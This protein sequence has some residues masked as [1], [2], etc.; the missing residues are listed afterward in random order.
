M[1]IR[2]ARL[3]ALALSASGHERMV[4]GP[5]AASKDSGLI[6]PQES[7]GLAHNEIEGPLVEI[8]SRSVFDKSAVGLPA[9]ASGGGAAYDLTPLLGRGVGREDCDESSVK[10]KGEAGGDRKAPKQSQFDRVLVIGRSQFRTN[11]GG[12][13]QAKRTQFP[14]GGNET[15][16]SV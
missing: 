7:P 9:V 13:G 4:K 6:S 2:Q 10:P 14:A 15:Q 3:E 1:A 16:A 12:I 11:R 5:M 8:G